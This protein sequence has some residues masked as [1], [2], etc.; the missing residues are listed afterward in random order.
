MVDKFVPG[1]IEPKWQKAWA[2]R[3]LFRAAEVPGPGK[4]YLLEMFPYPSGRLHMGHVRNYAIGDV[5]ARFWRMRGRQVLHPMGWD[6]F[7]LPA[8]QAAMERKLDPKKWTFDN[9]DEM[10]RQLR[11]LGLS[12]DWEREFATCVPEYYRWEQLVFVRMLERGLAYR[13]RSL[14][15]WS[16]AL[17]TVLAN[18]QVIDGRDYK[19]GEPVVQ[20]ELSQWFLRTTAYADRLLEGIEQLSGKWPERVLL[21]QRAR[22]G[23]SEGTEIVFPLE[24][25]AGGEKAVVV[26]TTRPD[27]LFGVTFMSLAAEHPLAVALAEG[28]GREAEVKAFVEKTRND[29]RRQRAEEITK[30]GCFTGA[31]CTNPATGGRVPIYIANFVLMDYGTGAVMAVP[32]HDQRDFEFARKYD[33]PIRVVIQ[34]AGAKLDPATMDAAYVEP[35]S[36]VNSGEFDGIPNEEGM[37]RI[38]AWLKERGQGGPT[39]SWRLRDWCVSRQR[40]WGCPIPVVHCEKCGVVGVPEAELP[41]LLPE[42]LVFDVRGGNPLARHPAFTKAACPKCGGP[43]RRE[44]DTLDTFVESSWYFLR[45]TDP[46]W[47]RGPFRPDRAKA[48][49]PVDQYIGGHEHAV[50]HLMYARFYH[51]VLKDLGFLPPDVPEEPF[52]RLLTQGMVCK[53]TNY[54][55]DE[56][57]N[58]VWHYPEEVSDGISTLDG[59]KVTVGRIEKMSKSRRN[60]VGLEA[61]VAGY[62]A[63]TARLFTLFAAPPE[64][65]LEWRDEGAEG[66]WRFLQ[67]VWRLTLEG[68]DAV[69]RAPEAV[70]DAEPG[71]RWRKLRRTTHQTIRRVTQDVDGRFHLNT[72]VAA[73]MELC[74][75][76][77]EAGLPPAWDAATTTSC[78]P[79]PDPDPRAAQAIHREAITSLL[80]LL[81]PFAPHVCD[82]LWS[83]LGF[84]GT[85]L[86]AGWPSFDPKVAAEDTIVYPVQV[87][88]KLR[89]Q[90]AVAPDASKDD[91]LAAA[92]AE[93]NVARHLAGKTIVKTVFVERR[94][95]NFVVK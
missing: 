44:T 60:V 65:D 94:L 79:E 49:M 43:G 34:P 57:G 83:R 4:F 35:G 19:L 29:I 37:K 26:F 76:L 33:L 66:C 38:T 64:K 7:G 28:T 42:D 72:A 3:G 93:A 67:R 74:N 41:V 17:Q 16:E 15:N 14:V 86:E 11:L 78:T 18:E 25:P 6:A 2:E 88:G 52:S 75:A 1:E 13:K 12:Y 50:G 70:P 82:E 36:Q 10:G 77:S 47:D 5:A 31:C 51:K 63:D 53:E 48:W 8:E 84:E 62:G 32:A 20:K 40:S 54:T 45:Y 80:R 59:R 39:V 24:K 95:V 61:F 58:P 87:L 9:I 85:V 22:I 55:V 89:G 91:V 46:K 71:E 30:E 23:R 27:T 90:V 68:A 56:V 92:K 81:S 73:I 69:G 21:E